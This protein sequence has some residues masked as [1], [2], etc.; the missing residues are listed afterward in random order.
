[1]TRPGRGGTVPGTRLVLGAWLAAMLLA[2]STPAQAVAPTLFVDKNNSGCSDSGAGT[3]TQPFCTIS[4]AA[5]VAV[6]GQTVVVNAGQ[7][8]ED[9]NP[10]NSGTSTAPIVFTAATGAAV[11][12]LG[13]TNGW[14]ISGKSFIK[15]HGFA[16]TQTTGPGIAISNSSNITI[17][18]NHVSFAGQPISGL[19]AKGI[20]VTGSSNTLIVGNQTAHNSDAGISMGS[21]NTGIEIRNNV[22]FSNA[23]QFVRL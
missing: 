13:Q 7:Y 15:V 14:T 4:K 11:T 10:A 3:Q 9:D 6:A 12:I 2:N 1:M 20:Q 18:S 21:G 5:S 19:S 8:A 22:S 17:D 23:S 16:I